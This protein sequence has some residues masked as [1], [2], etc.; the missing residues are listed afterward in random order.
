MRV[1]ILLPHPIRA[2]TLASKILNLG[3]VSA[4]SFRGS[5]M[6]D[7]TENKDGVRDEDI[8]GHGDAVLDRE[9]AGS[10]DEWTGGLVRLGGDIA[11]FTRD[12]GNAA[13][14]FYSG[15]GQV[16]FLSRNAMVV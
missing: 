6:S 5:N 14:Q 3:E 2:D 9:N 4:P 11:R 10:L 15:V 12:V 8:A 1:D 7:E 13:E 16:R